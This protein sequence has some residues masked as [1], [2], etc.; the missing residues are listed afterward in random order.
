MTE[1]FVLLH[2]SDVCDGKEKS[3]FEIPN[4]VRKWMGQLVQAWALQEDAKIMGH[5]HEWQTKYVTIRDVD[6]ASGMYCECG[7]ELWQDD[8]VG[9]INVLEDIAYGPCLVNDVNAARARQALQGT[10]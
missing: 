5:R 10:T 6:C 4:S 2:G 1:L 3:V 9:A 8:V 7:V